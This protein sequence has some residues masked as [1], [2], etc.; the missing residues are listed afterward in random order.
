MKHY[1]VFI[2]MS[3]CFVAPAVDRPIAIFLAVACLIAAL[4]IFAFDDTSER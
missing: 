2:L 3:T 4:V 1:Q